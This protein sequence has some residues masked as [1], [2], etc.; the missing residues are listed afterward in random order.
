MSAETPVPDH[1]SR[2]DFA[3][4]KILRYFNLLELNLGFC[5]RSLENP[6]D[7]DRSH[8]WLA[9][10]SVRE[11]V[12]RFTKLVAEKG[13]VGERQELD[14]WKEAAAST[15]CLRNF[16]VHGTW[17]YL[18]TRQGAPLRFRIP[19]WRSEEIRGSN[20]PT[21]TLEELEADAKAIQ[22]V[23]ERFAKLRRKYGV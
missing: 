11:K 19:P 23:F 6:D 22:S 7:V 8:G 17:E 5:I 9:G 18:S 21:M 3:L 2:V 1:E 20:S 16:Y 4:G 10:S 12:E 15:R 13:F 14:D